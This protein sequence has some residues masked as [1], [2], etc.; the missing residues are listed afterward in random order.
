MR[1]DRRGKI[2]RSSTFEKD[3]SEDLKA[4]L[5]SEPYLKVEPGEKLDFVPKI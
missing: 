1:V 5:T 3:E 4:G 2:I